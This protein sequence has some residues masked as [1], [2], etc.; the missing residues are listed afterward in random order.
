M[1]QLRL[2]YLLTFL[3]V[4]S[5]TTPTIMSYADLNFEL[6]ELL[7]KGEEEENKGKESFKDEEVKILDLGNQ[8]L[9]FALSTKSKK[10]AFYLGH[11]QNDYVR[12]VSPPP[13]RTS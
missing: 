10:V 1:I 3:F 5:I 11:Y 9:G 2:T 6:T 13:E 8:V 4:I 12:I 7:D